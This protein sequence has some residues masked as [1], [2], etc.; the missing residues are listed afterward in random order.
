MLNA[1]DAPAARVPPISV[2]AVILKEG[3]P[4]TAKKS[5]GSVVTSKSSTT[6][7]F[8]SAM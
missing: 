2:V 5:A 1:F 6:R 4:R 8:I 3:T 7:N